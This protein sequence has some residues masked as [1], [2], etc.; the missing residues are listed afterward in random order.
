M[1]RRERSRSPH[2]VVPAPAT[3]PAAL[4]LFVLL[5]VAAP[6]ARADDT[7][8]HPGD[9]PTYNVEVEPHLLLGWDNVYSAGGVGLGARFSI[10]IVD[11]GF[12][13]EINDSVAISFGAD[14]VYYGSCWYHGDC[15]AT[16]LDFPVAMQWNFYVARRW[17]VFGEPGLLIYHGF[18]SDC[19][20]NGNCPGSPHVTGLEPAIYVGG[21]YHMSE[22][23]ALTMRIGFPAFS[24][25]V[26][27][28]P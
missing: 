7:I 13:E 20:N 15:T 18:V 9:H 19:P 23:A 24:F 3:L 8:K 26:S 17:S 14:L 22:K 21:R 6:S 10:P 5:V 11:N 27:F 16:Y 2:A 25:G 28:F 1:T 12:V 4:V